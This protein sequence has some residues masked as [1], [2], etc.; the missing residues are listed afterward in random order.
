MPFERPPHPHLPH[1]AS[2]NKPSG[3]PNEL[4]PYVPEAQQ[5]IE[6][7]QE[8]FHAIAGDRSI[9]YKIGN[10]FVIDLKA[11]EV[12]LD[13]R[14]WQWAKEKGLS[15]W[16]ILWSVCHEI[17]HYRDLREAPEDI[18]KNFEYLE[19]RAKELAPPVLE[20]W[21]EKSGGTL[22]DY[23]TA[24]VAKTFVYQRLHLLYNCL[25]DIYDNQTIGLRSGIFSPTGSQAPEVERLYRD[26]LF[27]TRPKEIGKPPQTQEAADYEQL[28]KS[29]QLAYALLRRQMVPNQAVLISPNVQ[30]KLQ[31]FSD[32]AAQRLNITLEK[33]VASCTS[34]ANRKARNPGWR[35]ERIKQAAE[36][37]FVELLLQDLRKRP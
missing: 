12:T 6:D 17:G 26:Y 16:Q 37:A 33:E 10:G 28:P 31:G 21:R 11:G 23:L 15:Q 35:Y 1:E 3:I 20:I 13:V 36:P 25:D 34:P 14:D 9:T 22:P 8:I 19:G 7:H 29:Y 24:H 2:E 18:L 5:F 32:A 30:T 4:A 27:P